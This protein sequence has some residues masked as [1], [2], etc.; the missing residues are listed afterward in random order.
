LQLDGDGALQVAALSGAFE[1]RRAGSASIMSAGRSLRFAADSGEA[2]AV[3]PG[4]FKGCLAKLDKTYLLHDE[5]SNAVLALQGSSINGKSG[6]RVSVVGKPDTAAAPV[7]GA[8]QV[9]QV[10]RFTV[11][12]HGCSAKFAM[13]GAAAGTAGAGAA[14]AGTAGAA[15]G[16]AGATV[17]AISSAT[18]AVIGVAAASAALIPTIA[19]TSGSSSS[20]ISPSSR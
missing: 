6:D 20:S 16:A 9:I 11:D 17:G 18:I 12:G 7:A 19:L 8:S 2:G 4:Q 15:A 13:A 5:S 10:L 3:A 14:A 1:I